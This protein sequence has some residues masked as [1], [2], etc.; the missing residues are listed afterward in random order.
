MILGYICTA[1]KQWEEKKINLVVFC[2]VSRKILKFAK[3]KCKTCNDIIWKHMIVYPCYL[4][5]LKSTVLVHVETEHWTDDN[6]IEK[7]W[8]LDK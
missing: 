3:V 8:W 1:S 6:F 2:V 4:Y 7:I 5:N